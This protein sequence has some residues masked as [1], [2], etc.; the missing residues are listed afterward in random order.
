MVEV[1]VFTVT[2]AGGTVGIGVGV[3]VG[4]GV[5]VGSGVEVGGTGVG[6]ETSSELPA[7]VAV[8]GAEITGLFTGVFAFAAFGP[9]QP[10]RQV[11]AAVSINIYITFLFCI[12]LFLAS[13]TNEN[14]YLYVIP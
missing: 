1:S 9:V 5:A 3:G 14:Y 12:I 7:G 2:G 4:V 13:K 11:T 10:A 6:V 8:A